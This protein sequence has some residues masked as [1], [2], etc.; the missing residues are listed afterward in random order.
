M[1]AAEIVSRTTNDVDAIAV[2]GEVDGDIIYACPL[3]EFLKECVRGVAEEERLRP[4]WLNAATA[5]LMTDLHRFPAD[6]FA[7]LVKRSHGEWLKVSF[8]GGTG[9]VCLEMLRGRRPE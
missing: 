6:F 8:I 5:L 3:P 2:R 1:I 4:N 7:D 9:Q